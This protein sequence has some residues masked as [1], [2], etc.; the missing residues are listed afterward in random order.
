MSSF[1]NPLLLI[2]P[3]DDT[4]WTLY[5]EFDYYDD[6]G[7]TYK[8]PAGFKT[9]FASVPRILWSIFPPYGRY[10]KAS[11][12]HDYFYRTNSVSKDKADL[13]FK[14]AMSIL[15]VQKWKINILYKAVCWFGSKAYKKHSIT[16]TQEN[17]S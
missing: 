3:D 10:G 1:T 12:L 5:Q 6:D 9:D 17:P 14:R 2:A 16:K 13:E 15:H 8:V 7:V 11:V 4:E